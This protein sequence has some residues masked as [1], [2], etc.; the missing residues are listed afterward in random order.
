MVRVYVSSTIADLKTERRVVMDWLVAAQHQVVH[1]YRPNSATVRESCLDDVDTCDLY[2]LILGHRYGF[3]PADGNPEDFS[4]THLEFRRAGQSG[5]PRIALLRTSIPDANLSDFAN[6]QKAALVSAFRAEVARE[7]RPAEFSDLQGLIQGLSTGV[8]AELEKLEMREQ[9][10]DEYQAGSLV[11]RLPPRPAFLTGREELLAGLDDRLTE[12][13]RREP[14]VV[15]LTGLGGAGK[16]SVAVEYAHRH[17]DQV[18]VAWQLPAE[19]ATVLAAGF[20]ELAARLDIGRAAASGD[21]VAAVH[22]ALAAYPGEW[23]LIFD[24]APGQGPVRA[25][26]PPAGNGRVLITSQSAVWPPGQMVEVPVLNPEVAAVFLVTR[27]GDPDSQAAAAL[28]AELGGLP[29]ALEQAA[30]YV[31]AAGTTLAEY[32]SVF[33]ARRADLLARG[34]AAGHPESVVATL[35]LAL[36]RLEAEAPAAAALLR[37]LACLAPEPVPLRLLLEPSRKRLRRRAEQL[38]GPLLYDPI[39][40]TDAVAA[41]RKYSLVTPAGHGLV[42][43]HRLVQDVIISLMPEE[44]AAVWVR[45]A[46]GLVESAVPATVTRPENWPACALLLPHTQA[47]LEDSSRGM[48]RIAQYLGESGN[49][50]AA[51]DLQSRVAAARWP[52]LGKDHR[53]YLADQNRLA[54]WTGE[55]GDPGAA[56]DRYAELLPRDESVL[57]AEHRTTLSTRSYLAFWT[58]EAGDPAT[59][60]EMFAELLPVEERVLGAE[61]PATLGTRGNLARWTGDAGDPG[62]ARQMFTELLPVDVR[63]LGAYHRTTLVARDGLAR[64]TGEVG[65]PATAREMFAELLADVGRV[66]GPARPFALAIRGSLARWT[67]EAGDPA[68]ARAMYAELLPDMERL[69]G[70]GHRNTLRSR[71]G[72]ARWT[73]ESGNPVLARDLLVELLSVYE[74]NLGPQHPDTLA[75]R[76]CLAYWTERSRK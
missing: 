74:M 46:G 61:H 9:R 20:G 73:G 44:E 58:G 52:L 24:N 64:W 63:V 51:R 10:H 59:A 56:R 39:E 37:L 54:R 76:A 23:L 57:G 36:S 21:P 75:T 1:S 62:A 26:F 11:L 65:D 33:G 68:A 16:T 13:E 48:V 53:A 71:A 41:L 66:L 25:F 38:I 18:G 47:V 17:L 22:T 42:L 69:V 55:A 35:G 19:D 49:Y 67:G 5:I 6:P 30:A 34:E 3:Q 2:V 31:Q 32:L 45:L 27:S 28:G 29:L 70:P 4:I 12:Q 40:V 50:S 8:L 14:R 43:V 60:R 7:V 72:L 15:T